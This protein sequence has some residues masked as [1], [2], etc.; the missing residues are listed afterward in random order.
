M[1]FR[2]MRAKL[3]QT[4]KKGDWF[5]QPQPFMEKSDVS[6]L[7]FDTPQ[8]AS[9][10][11]IV[12]FLTS[13]Y[14]PEV[15]AYAICDVA[16]IRS[17]ALQL[18]QVPLTRKATRRLL[19]SPLYFIK[20]PNA[21]YYY[22]GEERAKEFILLLQHLL[23]AHDASSQSILYQCPTG[24]VCPQLPSFLRG[25]A[26]ADAIHHPLVLQ[27]SYVVDQLLQTGSVGPSL[28]VEGDYNERGVFLARWFMKIAKEFGSSR[29]LSASLL[30]MSRFD[31]PVRFDTSRQI[32]LAL[33]RMD[34]RE[35]DWKLKLS[36]GERSQ[37][38]PNKGW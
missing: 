33:S 27:L 15:Y 25:V 7:A 9:S 13:H 34:R 24:S 17:A 1:A 8:T 29:L 23:E 35:M 3:R 20:N 14:I 22:L 31:L 26:L 37:F 2:W 10:E 5:G 38:T 11:Q 12:A 4:I 21:L 18:N 36:R 16:D 19:I 30:L 28:Y 6:L 32:A